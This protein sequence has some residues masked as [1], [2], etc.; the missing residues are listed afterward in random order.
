MSSNTGFEFMKDADEDTVFVV[1]NFE[2][3]IFQQLYK[4]G[5]RIVAPPV[6]IKS[7]KMKKVVMHC[8]MTQFNYDNRFAQSSIKLRNLNST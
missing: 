2:G 1:E 6:V 3:S 8:N 5:C 7:A 4:E